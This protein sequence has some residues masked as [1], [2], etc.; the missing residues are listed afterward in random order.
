MLVNI[1]INKD[2]ILTLLISGIDTISHQI[3]IY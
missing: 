2:E 3:P 1:I